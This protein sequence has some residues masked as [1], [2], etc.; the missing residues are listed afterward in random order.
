MAFVTINSADI[1][2]GEP[3]K[4]ELFSTIKDD[5]DD[6]D[7]RLTT[8]EGSTNLYRPIQ[9]DVLGLYGDGIVQDGLMFDLVRF[10]ITI[11]NVVLFIHDA[12]SS[13]STTID[14]EYKR[15]V[16][17]FTSVLTSP[18]SVAAASGDY[19]TGTGTLG[20]TSLL[21]GDIL[22]LNVDAVQVLGQGFSVLI[23]FEVA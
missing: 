6:L 17:A 15:G 10:D 21:T 9:F 22:R 19:A 14:V 11:L 20:T 1:V 2:A 16:G 18:L 12:G 5:L 23:E 7:S 13:G 3:T 8:V 4:Q